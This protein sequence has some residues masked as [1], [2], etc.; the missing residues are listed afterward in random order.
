L[1]NNKETS[2]NLCDIF[3]NRGTASKKVYENRNGVQNVVSDWAFFILF[4]SL[5]IADS[6]YNPL[7]EFK[8]HLKAS[9]GLK[10]NLIKES[11]LFRAKRVED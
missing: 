1:T 3:P 2:L 11:K 6:D 7:D 4:L 10:E 5:V 8:I 9:Y